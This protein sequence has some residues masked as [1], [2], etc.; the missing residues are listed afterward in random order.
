M[1]DFLGGPIVYIII[2]QWIDQEAQF[3]CL[4]LCT[5]VWQQMIEHHVLLLDMAI[6]D[7]LRRYNNYPYIRNVSKVYCQ[8]NYG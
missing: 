2:Y 3:I 4:L 6:S 1:Y 5:E 7:G 8:L